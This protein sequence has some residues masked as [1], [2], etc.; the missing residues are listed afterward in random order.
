MSK[1]TVQLLID[2]LSEYQTL[3][4]DQNVIEELRTQANLNLEKAV[5]KIEKD[6]ANLAFIPID[7]RII[8]L[9]AN[10]KAYELK[11]RQ[12]KEDNS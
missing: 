2:L 10:F 9:N 11:V 6:T 8:K 5:T 7:E 4:V 1:L 3:L 12:L